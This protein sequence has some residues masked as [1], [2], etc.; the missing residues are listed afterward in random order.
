MLRAWTT[1]VREPKPELVR[2]PMPW[3]LT[4]GSIVVALLVMAGPRLGVWVGAM[5]AAGALLAIVMHAWYVRHPSDMPAPS[6]PQRWRTP[7]INSPLRKSPAT[8]GGLIFVVGSVFVV[9]VGL[10]SVTW[11]LF[12]AAVAGSVLAC[13]LLVWHMSHPKRGLPENLIVLR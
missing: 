13:A 1:F 4:G 7:Q 11:F 12:V 9:A 2:F 6:E 8:F 3:R 5:T 10:P